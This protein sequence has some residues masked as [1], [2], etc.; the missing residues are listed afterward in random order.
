MKSVEKTKKKGLL[1]SCIAHVVISRPSDPCLIAQCG[2]AL[3]V[4]GHDREMA[5]AAADRL[6]AT[7]RAS[8]GDFAG[9]LYDPDEAV[10][11]ALR[12]ARDATKP[13]I[14]ADTVTG[15]AVV[16]SEASR[17]AMVILR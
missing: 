8:E 3:V 10:T 11:E 5:E 13:V 4:Y 17:H 15:E 9:K 7:I 2:P 1:N 16:S 6:A 12:L 14:L